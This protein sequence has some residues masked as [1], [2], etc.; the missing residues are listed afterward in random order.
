MR[1]HKILMKVIFLSAVYVYDLYTHKSQNT[2]ESN[3]RTY[4]VT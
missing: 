4:E 3:P 1:I 2:S